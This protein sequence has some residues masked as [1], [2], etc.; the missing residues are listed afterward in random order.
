V[1]TDYK[2]RPEAQVLQPECNEFSATAGRPIRGEPFPMVAAGNEMDAPTMSRVSTADRTASTGSRV[3]PPR[4][5]QRPLRGPAETLFPTTPQRDRINAP[6]R[7]PRIAN[8][9]PPANGSL[10]PA[11]HQLQ[12]TKTSAAAWAIT[13]P[14]HK[15]EGPLQMRPSE[16]FPCGSDC[17][18][19]GDP[20]S[21]AEAPHRRAKKQR[22]I[23]DTRPSIRYH[24]DD[25]FGAGVNPRM[26]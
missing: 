1:S 3:P 13:I 18:S 21:H 7:T 9:L 11:G 2:F 8:A 5:R 20:P 23:E 22:G 6:A 16:G 24:H 12:H 15:A 19:C 26:A 4:I 25:P 14:Y 17:Q 10:S